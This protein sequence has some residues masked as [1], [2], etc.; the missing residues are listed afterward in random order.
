MSIHIDIKSCPRDEDVDTWF[1]ARYEEM[2]GGISF[3][4]CAEMTITPAVNEDDGDHATQIVLKDI[5]DEVNEDDPLSDMMNI[6][7]EDI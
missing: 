3:N 2:M 4:P 5:A 7:L 6:K 1:N